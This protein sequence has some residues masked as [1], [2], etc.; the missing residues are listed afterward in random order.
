M[1]KLK[2]HPTRDTGRIVQVTPESAGWTHVGF[3]VWKL[4][5]GAVAEGGEPGRE[6][7]LVFIGGKGHVFVGAKD[8]GVLGERNSPFEGKPWSVYIPAGERWKVTAENA[9]TLAVCTAPGEGG[10][11]PARVIAPDGLHQETRG[12][13]SNTRHVTNIIPEWDAAEGLLVV[14]VITPGGCTSSYPPHK[15]DSEAPPT[16]AQAPPNAVAATR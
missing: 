3:D 8:Y 7:C 15:H 10:K 5:P 2:I 12:K 14:E 11:H 1:S 6:V 16:P 9:V 13:G 4:K